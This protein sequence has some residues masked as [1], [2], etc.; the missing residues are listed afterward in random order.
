METLGVRPDVI[1]LT[2]GGSKSAVWRQMCADVFGYPV[3]GLAHAEGAALGAAIQALAA[4]DPRRPLAE[5]CDCCAPLD[6]ASRIEPCRNAVYPM[7]L[8]RMNELRTRV[9][10]D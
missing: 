7:L 3:I 9:F 5:W 2:G 10:P 4:C 6:E 8:A 1:R